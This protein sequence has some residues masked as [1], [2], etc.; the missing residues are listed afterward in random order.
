MKPADKYARAF[1]N[2]VADMS[3][4]TLGV[5]LLAILAR[6][7]RLVGLPGPAGPDLNPGQK[8]KTVLAT[9]LRETGDDRGE[10]VQRMYDSED[11]GE[12]VSREM[13]GKKRIKKIENKGESAGPGKVVDREME[14]IGDSAMSQPERIGE[15]EKTRSHGSGNEALETAPTTGVE[16]KKKRRKKANAIDDLFAGL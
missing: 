15:A 14:E 11:I 7:G 8:P 12:V 3:F 9:S 4:S 13:T 10:V 5:V 1:S 2:L 6:V 16:R